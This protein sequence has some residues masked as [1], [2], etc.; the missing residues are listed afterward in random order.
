MNIP[1]KP[2]SIDVEIHGN[3]VDGREI[4]AGSG[5]ML[6]VRN[7]ATGE[8]IHIKASKKVAFRAAKELKEAV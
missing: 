3:F 2:A 4:E 5:E 6:D 7:P 8:A 1:S